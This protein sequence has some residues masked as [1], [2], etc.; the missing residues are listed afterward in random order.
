MYKSFYQLQTNPFSLTPDLKFCYCHTGYMQAREYLDYALE[1]GEGFV[2]VTGRPGT[3]KTT[4][5]ESFLATL[6][7][8]RVKAA[9][10]AASGLDAEDL[11]RTVAYAYNLE[12]EGQ[13]KATLRHHIKQFFEEQLRSGRRALLIIDEAQGLPRPAL[14]ELRLLSDLQAGSHQLLQLF[15]V[16]QEELREQMSSPE[17]DHFQQRVIANYHLVPLDLMESRAYMEFRLRQAGWLGN[18]EITGDAVLDIFRFS[19]GVP[20]HINKLCN[21]LL[22]L[23]YG[24]GS[25]KL[26]S[27]DVQTI[28]EEMDD[29]LLRPIATNQSGEVAIAETLDIP[30][31]TPDLLSDLAIRMKERVFAKA[32]AMPAV[33]VAPGPA[34]L[35]AP[36]GSAGHAQDHTTFRE[37]SNDWTTLLT[38]I[39]GCQEKLVPSAV[40]LIVAALSISMVMDNS[41][42]EVGRQVAMLT[43]EPESPALL[44]AD[45]S[46]SEQQM[47]ASSIPVDTQQTPTAPVM[48]T[49]AVL[50]D[51]LQ[52]A[53]A[54]GDTILQLVLE[55]KLQ[56]TAAG[57]AQEQRATL[58]VTDEM[59]ER[60]IAYVKPMQGTTEQVPVDEVVSKV[61]S[62]ADMTADN[63]LQ[64]DASREAEIEDLIAQGR[65]ALEDDRLLTPAWD[66]AYLYFQSTL[67]LEPD[68][69][70]AIEGISQIVEHYVL[71]TNKALAKQDRMAADRYIARGLSIEPDNGELLAL[72]EELQVASDST[73][74]PIIRLGLEDNAA[75]QVEDTRKRTGNFFTLI[76]AFF[77]SNTK[78]H[79]E[80]LATNQKTSSYLYE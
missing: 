73:D 23:G 8:D 17:M 78:A 79:P 50:S 44:P 76:K 29:E 6:N 11:L 60:P 2:M 75:S 12:A 64:A 63:E 25:D 39:T 70:E 71:L 9:R 68:N 37:S 46:S 31:I 43:V 42:E 77:A 3:G 67:K 49:E 27:G 30:E 55:D 65:R 22:L 34:N 51:A 45:T 66:S 4:L 33:A 47:I 80:V 48:M 14:E 21:R 20:R 41:E 1:L 62:V 18:P 38:T 40:M 54:P 28:A 24:M 19:R 69:A 13:D 56:S 61:A 32:A 74:V 52:T 53:P 36:A 59:P 7:M 5:V 16:G 57:S 35:S 26:D 15:L 10:I 58:S 72:K